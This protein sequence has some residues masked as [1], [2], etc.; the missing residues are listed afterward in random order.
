MEEKRE[1]KRKEEE[2]DLRRVRN[3]KEAWGYINRKRRKREWITNNIRR[4]D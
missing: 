4:S 1:K 3:E 2:L